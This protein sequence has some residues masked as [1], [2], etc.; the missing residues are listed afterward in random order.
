[1]D[2]DVLKGVLVGAVLLLIMGGLVWFLVGLGGD[3]GDV[4]EAEHANISLEIIDR[5]FYRIVDY[6]AQ[7]L[8]YALYDNA[9]DCMPL[10]DSTLPRE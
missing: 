10:S 1:M 2:R 7:V 8:C 4:N 9:I 6:D 3:P 5:G